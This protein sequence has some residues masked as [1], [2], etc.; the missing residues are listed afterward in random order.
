M[1]HREETE[2]KQAS[3]VDNVEEVRYDVEGAATPL[4]SV[5][6]VVDLELSEEMDVEDE[7]DDDSE[8]QYY[9]QE[10][11]KHKK[12]IFILTSAGKPLYSR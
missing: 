11:P 8:R 10:W 9:C 2:E 1:L 6:D 3:P 7:L 12:H 5:L 4:E